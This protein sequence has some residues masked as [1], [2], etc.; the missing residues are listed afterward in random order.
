MGDSGKGRVVRTG[1]PAYEAVSFRFL[2]NLFLLFFS[3]FEHI[4][5]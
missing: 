3:G 4:L 1:P 5:A 2:K